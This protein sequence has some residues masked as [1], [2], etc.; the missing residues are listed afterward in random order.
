MG[1]ELGEG[2]NPQPQLCLEPLGKGVPLLNPKCSL[3]LS[4]KP[5]ALFL[6][7]I[8]CLFMSIPFPS[9]WPHRQVEKLRQAV[10]EMDREL[11]FGLWMWIFLYINKKNQNTPKMTSPASYSSMTEEDVRP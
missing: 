1:C 11:Y 2:L 5:M 8:H 3:F 9:L 6:L 7:H 10:S 4:P